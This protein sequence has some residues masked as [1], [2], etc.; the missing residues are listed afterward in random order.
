MS[1][2]K[3]FELHIIRLQV[4]PKDFEIRCHRQPS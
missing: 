1:R 3:V 2:G 4:D